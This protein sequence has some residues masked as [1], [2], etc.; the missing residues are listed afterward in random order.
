MPLRIAK[1]AIIALTST[2]FAQFEESAVKRV[3]V[4]TGDINADAY[5]VA[6][7]RCQVSTTELVRA[8][9]CEG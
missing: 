4:S 6:R 5:R 9:G 1:R 3:S 8:L 2:R 7:H